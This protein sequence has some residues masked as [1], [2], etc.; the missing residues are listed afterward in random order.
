MTDSNFA[1]S[2]KSLAQKLMRSALL[3]LILVSV[4]MVSSAPAGAQGRLPIVRDAEIE[5]LHER[6]LALAASHASGRLVSLL[7]GGYSLD[8]LARSAEAHVGA[9][10]G[11]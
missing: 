4:A 11:V 7:E 10:V 2:M 1:K 6:L 5:A 8:G 9:L 3:M